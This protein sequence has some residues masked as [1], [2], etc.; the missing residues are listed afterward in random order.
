VKI[1]EHRTWLEQNARRFE[2]KWGWL[3]PPKTRYRRASG[4][5]IWHFCQ[6]CPNW[7]AADFDEAAPANEYGLDTP[8]LPPGGECEQCKSLRARSECA[9]Y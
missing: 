2:E 9:F 6:N 3:P 8:P 5:S 1:P 4:G 7:P